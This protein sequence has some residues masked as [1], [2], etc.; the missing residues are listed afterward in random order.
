MK[1]VL[2]LSTLVALFTITFMACKKKT[3]D[4]IP[5]VDDAAALADFFERN[6]VPSQTFIIDN[7][8]GGTVTTTSGAKITFPPNVFVKNPRS[9]NIAAV[10]PV[11]VEWKECVSK[12]D[13]VLSNKGTISNGL[14][15]E[16]G[17]TWMIK[18]W[19]GTEVLNINAA[20]L[21]RV[22]L[23][24][25]SMVT[26]PML[27]FNANPAGNKNGGNI[28]W[29]QERGTITPLTTPFNN[30][31]CNVDS[32]G[33]GNA[34]RFLSSPNYALNTKIVGS[35]GEDLSKFSAM[36]VYKGKKIVWP[37][38]GRSAGA[39]TDTH[40]AKSQV[41]HVV[42]FGFINGVFTTALLQDQ[43]VTTDNQTFT[44]TLSNN[45]EAAFKSQLSS[46]L[47]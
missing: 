23:K 39:V 36:Y 24:R 6:V 35:K 31:F 25:D 47:L 38:H 18:P 46:I 22:N 30:Y 26:G 43:T 21:V 15:L 42:V 11:T 7:A 20:S 45:T 13:F 8:M 37:M 29:G 41:G 28:N 4:V 9:A 27:L 33:W 3:E 32:V 16:S 19:Q 12:T 10:G 14:P 34:D 40:V 5:P 1:K 44:V 17:G 2:L